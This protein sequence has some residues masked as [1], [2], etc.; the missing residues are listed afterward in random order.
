[1]PTLD[2]RQTGSSFVK[3]DGEEA[4]STQQSASTLATVVATVY[5]SDLESVLT[6]DASSATTESSSKSVQSNE[7]LETLK[8]LFLMRATV[9]AKKFLSAVMVILQ[10]PST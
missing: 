10:E 8:E 5:D 2:Q 9:N 7:Q 6:D 1:M 3:S 4:T